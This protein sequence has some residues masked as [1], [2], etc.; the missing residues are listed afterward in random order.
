MDHE[1][2]HLEIDT[3]KDEFVHPS[4]LPGWVDATVPTL[5]EALSVAE[6]QHDDGTYRSKQGWK[7]RK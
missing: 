3:A 5:G 2:D 4:P 7:V 6:W 1:D